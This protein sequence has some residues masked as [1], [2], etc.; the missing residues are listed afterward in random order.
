MALEFNDGRPMGEDGE[1]WKDRDPRQPGPECPA[2]MSR[3][4]IRQAVNDMAADEYMECSWRIITKMM[5][6][7]FLHALDMKGDLRLRMAEGVVKETDRRVRERYEDRTTDPMNEN[8]MR[9]AKIRLS[10]VMKNLFTESLLSDEF[11]EPMMKQ[12]RRRLRKQK[13]E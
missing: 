8:A 13:G 3:R 5:L 4:E 11:L 12:A 2:G 10:R 9:R 7:A 6:D 1:G